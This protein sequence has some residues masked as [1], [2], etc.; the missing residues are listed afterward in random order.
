MQ[1]HLRLLSGV[2]NGWSLYHPLL[3]II[4]AFMA[5]VHRRFFRI[6]IYSF[7]FYSGVGLYF[8]TF[9]FCKGT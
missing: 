9:Q 7:L 8:V 6:V 5:L 4:V 2:Q 3:E 1:R